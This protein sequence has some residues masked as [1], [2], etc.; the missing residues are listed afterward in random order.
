MAHYTD[1]I[2]QG[3]PTGQTRRERT[4]CSYRAY[5]PDLLTGRS[6]SLPGDLVADLADGDRAVANLQDRKTG[7]AS[8]ESVARLLLRAEAV[9]SSYIEGLQVNA[10]RLAKE[11][12]AEQVGL[13][14]NDDTARAVLGNIRAMGSA[15]DLADLERAL[16]VEDLCAL[17]RELLA[18]TRDERWGGV[19]REEQNWIGGV[20]PCRAAYVPPPHDH[21]LELLEDLCSYISGDDHSPIVQAA[22]AHAQFET[23]H[24]FVDGNGRVGRALIHLVLRRRGL[25][26]NFVPPVSLILA[27]NAGGYIASLVSFR[28]DAPAGSPVANEAAVQWIGR[29][30]NELLRAC[31]DAAAFAEQLDHL[32]AKWRDAAGSVRRNSATDLLLA[33]LPGLPILTVET[34]A[35]TIGRS[36]PRTNE[37]VNHLRDCGILRQG[38]IG[39]RNRVFEVADLLDE[40]TR[41]ERR[42]ASPAADTAVARPTRTVPA[43][44][45]PMP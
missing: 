8:V 34:A 9:G 42:L 29:F 18:G 45:N 40:I 41:L 6:L 38:T 30:V 33:A 4:A 2:W 17:H 25:A 35:E 22:L 3:T 1:L 32:E 12:F 20:N 36:S 24:P 44:P 5:I 19:I 39:R 13:P 7:L 26:P 23:I 16:T 28:Y 10:R 37:A 31:E 27:T 14:T 11:E 21:V 43:G 15:L